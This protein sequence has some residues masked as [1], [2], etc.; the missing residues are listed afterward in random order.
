MRLSVCT[1]NKCIPK[2]RKG[3]KNIKYSNR[4]YN[5]F[6]HGFLRYNVLFLDVLQTVKPN[7]L[8][9]IKKIT[10][11][12]SCQRVYIAMESLKSRV[13]GLTSLTCN[14][15]FVQNPPSAF[16]V[17]DKLHIHDDSKLYSIFHPLF[18]PVQ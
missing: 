11:H 8:T 16:D 7:E 14:F 13:I 2:N 4:W 1:K 3:K 18:V 6:N 5:N 12:L 15:L 10:R 17:F 9:L